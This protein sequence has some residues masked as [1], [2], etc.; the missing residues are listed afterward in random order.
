MV[1]STALPGPPTV[2]GS[3]AGLDFETKLSYKENAVELLEQALAKPKYRCQPIA[4]GTNTDPYQPLEREQRV[5]RQI[6]E[7]LQR[8]RHP[9]FHCHQKFIDFAGP[10]SAG[11]DGAPAALLGKD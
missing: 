4:L 5:T 8:H 7:V 9:V 11:S 3:V 2:T 6:L 10:G 1:A